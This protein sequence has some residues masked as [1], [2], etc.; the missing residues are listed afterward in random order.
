[1]HVRYAEDV[2]DGLGQ[3]HRIED[4]RSVYRAALPRGLR[5]PAAFGLFVQLHNEK[6]PQIADV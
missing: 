2:I 6:S 1:M 4:A 5:V 3:I